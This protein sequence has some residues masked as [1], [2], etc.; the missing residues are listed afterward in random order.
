MDNIQQTEQQKLEHI[1]QGSLDSS[2]NKWTG[3]RE[4]MPAMDECKANRESLQSKLERK[5]DIGSNEQHGM[6]VREGKDEVR[7]GNLRKVTPLIC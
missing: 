6:Q 5:K 2:K 3:L 1:I 4:L 7:R